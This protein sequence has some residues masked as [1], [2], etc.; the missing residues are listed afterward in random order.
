MIF[1]HSILSSNIIT[2][3]FVEK[4]A[5][6]LI[7]LIISV[8]SRF[9]D[10]SVS[11]KQFYFISVDF[12]LIPLYQVNL[13]DWSVGSFDFYHKIEFVSSSLSRIPR[14]FFSKPVL[15]AIFS[16]DTLF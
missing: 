6:Q 2:L 16:I 9:F 5:Y 15:S 4:F 1:V 12:L 11:V 10:L 7:L 14:H 13:F 8:T 3:I